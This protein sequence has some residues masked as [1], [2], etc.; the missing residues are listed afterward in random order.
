VQVGRSRFSRC[1]YLIID[2]GSRLLVRKLGQELVAITFFDVQDVAHL[3]AAFRAG[4]L[5]A[6]K[7][8]G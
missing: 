3:D 1:C 8:T 2:L 4:H 7:K 6:Q 5:A